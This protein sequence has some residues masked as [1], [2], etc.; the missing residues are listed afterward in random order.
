M[1]LHTLQMV[2]VGPFADEQTIDFDRL[3]AGGLFLFEGP[4]GVGKS[5]ILDAVT[6]ALYGGPSGATGDPARLRSDF[7]DPQA[8]PEVR[9]EFSVRGGRHRITR[10]PEYTRPKK[11]GS[12]TTKEKASVHLERSRG[13]GW[14]SR[15]HSKDEV[16]A[17]IGD[18]L[19]LTREQFRQVV[20]LPQGEFAAFLRAGDDDRR[21]VLTK[22]FG[23][24][25]FSRITEALQERARQAGRALREADSA[26]RA[27]LAAAG[28]A[29]GPVADEH[30]ELTGLPVS[31]AMDRLVALDE[32]LTA[33]CQR[34]RV[35]LADADT[36][37]HT[38][39]TA[40]RA[41]EDVAERVTRRVALEA[42]LALADQQRAEHDARCE[43]L[44]AAR[45]ATPVGTF[46]EIADDA[47][48]MV[49]LLRAQI[50]TVSTDPLI[51]GEHRQGRGWEVLADEAAR[52]RTSVGALAHAVTVEA[53]LEQARDEVGQLGAQAGS[54]RAHLD[55]A[56]TR[57]GELPAKTAAA[58]AELATAQQL[59]AGLDGR[60][61]VLAAESK[62]AEA[63]Q[64]VVELTITLDDL[65]EAKRLAVHAHSEARDH[66]DLL[67][68]LRL[69]DVRGQLAARLVSGDPCLVC[70]SAEHPAPATSA[71]GS[72]TEGQIRTAAAHRDHARL[73]VDEAE[74]ALVRA[75][76]DLEHAAGL[77][78]GATPG[79]CQA[80]ID[81]VTAEVTQGAA[82]EQSLAG[83]E[84]EVL[85]LVGEQEALSASLIDLT[86]K[87]STAEGSLAHAAEALA[88]HEAEVTRARGEHPTVEARIAELTDHAAMLDALA[89]GVRELAGAMAN[90]SAAHSRAEAEAR[91]AGFATASQARAAFLAPAD[92]ATVEAGV[93][94][95]ESAVSAAR[96]QLESEAL[97]SVADL[98]LTAAAAEAADVTRALT[99][100]EQAART[101]QQQAAI[102]DQQRDRF[103]LRMAEVHQRAVERAHLA[104]A[105]EELVALDEY[106]RGMAGSP[107]MSLS[108]F[109]L[110][111]WFEQVVAAAN[112]R[113][114]AMSAGK[115]QLIRV[116]DGARR[117]AR[118]GLG[119][120]VLDRHT[121]KERGPGTLSGGETF[122]TSLALALGLA[123]VV[124]AQAGGAQLDTLFI[125]EGFGTLDPDTLD[126]V[127]GVIDELRGNGRVVGIIS[128][129]TDLK[130]RIPERLTVRRV[131]PDGP[132]HVQVRA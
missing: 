70:G 59:A 50:S 54:L 20:L 53:A 11:R 107:R 85:R 77:A 56:R 120:T 110:R 3:S 132:S 33:Q 115:Y 100:A 39:R 4:T 72:V 10:T 89:V 34:A 5:M 98:D 113:L 49:E 84:S 51:A 21:A 42:E 67:L 108:T 111:Y 104:A 12:G 45:R 6:F 43:Q 95:W 71:P 35:A 65:R 14:E 47:T 129:V 13:A 75:G 44:A 119:L 81:T 28:E 116:D 61:A 24:Q 103:A 68:E 60:R 27:A 83:L 46:V 106:A 102:A 109:V 127:M 101:A 32:T 64:R 69:S 26:L 55:A 78:D 66:H 22:L 93:T 126:D 125:D 16:G 31:Q 8:R 88:G 80:R 18:L 19:G 15:S 73:A 9:L 128:H 30:G 1:R 48:H 17:I 38:A 2:A 91:R 36:E 117:D 122:Y 74:V 118:V 99:A 121:G 130:E 76:G 82:A 58:R 131:R 41:A 62:R 123:D 94:Q 114:A 124:V 23:T 97:R 92:L 25:F 90:A 52:M 87:V 29:A 40:A 86:Q 105:G 7:A 79:E 112:L 63:A 57:S 37:V 96:R